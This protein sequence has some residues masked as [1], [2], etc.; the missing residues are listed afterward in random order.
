MKRALKTVRPEIEHRI[1]AIENGNLEG[2]PQDNVLTWHI[3]QA[4]RKKEPRQ[5]LADVIACRVFATMF[6]ALESTTLTMTH[7]LFNLC[8]TDAAKDVWKTLEKEGCSAFSAK[9]D[10]SIVNN[11]KF[12][13]SAIKETLRL[14]TSIKALGVQVIQP[15]GLDL[16]GY[17]IHLP[18]GSRVSV[19]VWGIHHDED[20]YPAAHNYEAFRF[21]QDGKSKDSLVSLSENYLSFGLGKHSCPGRY[22]A[23]IALKLFLAYLAVHYDVEAVHE[24]PRSEEHTSE[25]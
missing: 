25:L 15:A 21:V 17:D 19:P 1:T 13:D 7:T 9:V 16:K 2:I 11:L 24:R 8:A 12:A 14:H 5:G 23:A 3:E 6:A 18:Q 22:F 10:Q 20:V 4:L